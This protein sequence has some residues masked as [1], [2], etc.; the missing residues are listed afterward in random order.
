MTQQIEY[1]EDKILFEEIKKT[2]SENDIY[3]T[4]DAITQM[5]SIGDH[6]AIVVVTRN[7]FGDV[8]STFCKMD[9]KLKTFQAS[10]FNEHDFALEIS[11]L[12]RKKSVKINTRTTKTA[13]SR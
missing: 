6:K 13:K 9:K 1:N 2:I 12:C 10:A 4:S 11:E 3:E 7:N 8:L 5:Y